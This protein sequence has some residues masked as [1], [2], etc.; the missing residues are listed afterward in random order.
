MFGFRVW[1]LGGVSGLGFWC[2]GVA[3]SFGIW[4][5]WILLLRFLGG[6]VWR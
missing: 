5:L 1:R 6:L 2:L 3:V 4:G